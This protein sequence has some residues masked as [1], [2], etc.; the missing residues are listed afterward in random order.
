MINI[1][2]IKDRPKFITN[3]SINFL[4]LTGSHAYGGETPESDYDYYGFMVP[5]IA[6]V[7]PHVNGKINGFG[8]Q[9]NRFEQWAVQSRQIEDREVDV[10]IYNIVKYFHLIMGCNPNMIHSLFV[11]DGCIVHVDNIGELVRKNKQMF[12]SEKAFHTFRGMAFSHLHRIKN[13]KRKPEGN[14]AKV[15]EKYGYDTKDASYCLRVIW[16]LEEILFEGD[17]HIDRF[18][19]EIVAI[20]NG[21]YNLREVIDIFEDK[22]DE[23]EKNRENSVI[24]YAPDEEKIKKLLINCLEEKYGDLKRIGFGAEA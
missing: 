17:L 9:N 11:P 12:L 15:V 22:V 23:I 5:P 10:T 1:E 13:R 24:P 21:K 20:R 2:Q 14:R 3:D 18:G 4:T 16:E 7:F 6:E 19:K 8:R